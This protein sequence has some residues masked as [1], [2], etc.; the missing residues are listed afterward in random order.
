MTLTNNLRPSR[1]DRHFSNDTANT[2]SEITQ[3]RLT[4]MENYLG[5]MDKDLQ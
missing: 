4:Q 3:L 1:Y 2:G 5:K